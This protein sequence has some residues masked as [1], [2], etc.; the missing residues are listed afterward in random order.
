MQEQ[1]AI[2]VEDHDEWI[3]VADDHEPDR[4]WKSFD[5]AMKALE[6]EGWQVVHGPAPIR[7]DFESGAFDRFRPRGYRLRRAIQ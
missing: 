5:A 1:S 3:F 7:P 6:R 4:V 2:L